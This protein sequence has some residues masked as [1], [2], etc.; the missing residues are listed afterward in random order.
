MPDY[1]INTPAEEAELDRICSSLAAVCCA[2]SFIV[3]SETTWEQFKSWLVGILD[4]ETSRLVD[5]S[6]TRDSLLT[7]IKEVDKLLMVSEGMKVLGS[8]NVTPPWLRD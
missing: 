4:C 7:A 5:T 3:S 2:A 1:A 6:L 8:S